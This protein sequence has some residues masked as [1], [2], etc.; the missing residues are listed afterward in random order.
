MIANTLMNVLILELKI[1]C[2]PDKFYGR[3]KFGQY[4]EVKDRAPLHLHTKNSY[5]NPI[6]VRLVVGV[7]WCKCSFVNSFKSGCLGTCIAPFTYFNF[8][9]NIEKT[10]MNNPTSSNA[11]VNNSM[12]QKRSKYKLLGFFKKRLQDSVYPWSTGIQSGGPNIG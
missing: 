10:F 5:R 8:T 7:R 2:G 3:S 11:H 4:D 1:Y 9:R 6:L 12:S